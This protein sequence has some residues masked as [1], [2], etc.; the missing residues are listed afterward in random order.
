MRW[1][2]LC[3]LCTTV[4]AMHE[5]KRESLCNFRSGS[6]SITTLIT[7][8]RPSTPAAKSVSASLLRLSSPNGPGQ[9]PSCNHPLLP[10]RYVSSFINCFVTSEVVA[11]LFEFY[12]ITLNPRFCFLTL[13]RSHFRHFLRKFPRFESHM[14]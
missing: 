2:G 12:H 5:C 9:P 13:K 11:S 3:N 14:F 10:A 4:Y 8:T 7:L 6:M 1:I